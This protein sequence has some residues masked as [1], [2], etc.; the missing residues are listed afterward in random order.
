MSNKVKDNLEDTVQ[1]LQ[2]WLIT[3]GPAELDNNALNIFVI[4]SSHG[5]QR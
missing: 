2:S 4:I 3:Y 1:G 5:D